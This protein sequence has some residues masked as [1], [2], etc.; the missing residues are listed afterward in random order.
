MTLGYSM[1]D[2]VLGFL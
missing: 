1:S 2:M